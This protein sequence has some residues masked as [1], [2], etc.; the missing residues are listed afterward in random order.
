MPASIAGTSKTPVALVIRR[1]HDAR[2]LVFLTSTVAPG[3]GPP[4]ESSTVPESAVLVVPL[5]RTRRNCRAETTRRSQSPRSCVAWILR[6]V[7]SRL[8][9]F[10]CVAYRDASSVVAALMGRISQLR[11]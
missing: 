1:R 2:A 9:Q 10:G 11:L 6:R 8:V 3:S 5:G 7:V 4:P